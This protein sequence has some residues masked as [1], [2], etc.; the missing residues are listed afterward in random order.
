MD[1]STTLVSVR[2]V[3]V[4][5]NMNLPETRPGEADKEP[6]I[7]RK[8]TEVQLAHAYLGFAIIC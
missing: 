7:I 1:K 5:T 8:S 6:T 4:S 2:S 3:R